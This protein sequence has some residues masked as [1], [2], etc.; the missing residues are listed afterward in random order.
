M[1]HRIAL[2]CLAT[3][4]RIASPVAVLALAISTMIACAPQSPPARLVFADEAHR[5]AATGETLLIDVRLPRERR[6]PLFA[7]HTLAWIPFEPAETP[8]FVASVDRIV[9]GDRGRSMTLICEVGERSELARR[10]LVSFRFRN[11]MSIDHGYHSWSE[12]GLPLSDD[13]VHSIHQ[14]S[15]E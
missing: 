2:D 8:A 12:D 9:L 4:E 15:R 13:T 3:G 7:Q 6:R 1:N 14:P 10:A 5:S 11:V